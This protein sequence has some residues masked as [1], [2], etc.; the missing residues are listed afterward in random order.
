MLRKLKE[1]TVP[2]ILSNK[3]RSGFTMIELLVALLILI[4]LVLIAMSIYTNYIGKARVTVAT[5]VLDN[6]GKALTE[7][8]MDYG[9]YP[10]SINFTNCVDEAERRVFPSGLCDQ[11]KEE[12]DS[13]EYSIS[14]SIY[15]V[16]A[17]AKDA[18]HTV[19]TLSD[20]RIT[21]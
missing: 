18:K 13:P 6:A 19:L 5:S 4:V 2:V 15:T 11:I 20:S 9:T 1:K 14:G 8:Q 7:Y 21:Q 3:R 17:R 12:L 10:G 16:T